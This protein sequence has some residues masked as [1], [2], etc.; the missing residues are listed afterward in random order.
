MNKKQSED[1]ELENIPYDDLIK[2]AVSA[3]PY[4]TE[5]SLMYRT[6][7]N[8]AMWACLEAAAELQDLRGFSGVL[9]D[10]NIVCTQSWN[11]AIQEASK[12][13]RGF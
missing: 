5:S 11:Y 6:I 9:P 2:A 12:L 10:G 7:N 13:L 3:N 1:M 4:E 8:G